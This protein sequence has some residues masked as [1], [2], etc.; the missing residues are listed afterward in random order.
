M[1]IDSVQ[2]T[3][4]YKAGLTMIWEF[5]IACVRIE[6]VNF[7]ESI[8]TFLR[9]K[10]NCRYNIIRVLIVSGWPYS[11]VDISATNVTPA[12]PSGNN[13]DYSIQGAK[14]VLSYILGLG[15]FVIHRA[16]EFWS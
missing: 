9:D 7:R 13:V 12:P 16:S 10:Q 14:K 1:K 15:V 5:E 2:G 3:S 8:W 6:L 4:V 11:R